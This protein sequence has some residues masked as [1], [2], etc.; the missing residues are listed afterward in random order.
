MSV[1]IRLV[2]PEELVRQPVIA[3]LVRRYQVEP[4]I[5]Q[6]QVEESSAWMTLELVG[7]RSEIDASIEWLRAEGVGVE[8]L[9]DVVES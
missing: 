3:R 7:E 9:S 4:N 5:R 2:Y 1:R 6:A 8:P